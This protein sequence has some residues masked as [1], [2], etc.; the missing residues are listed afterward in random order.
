MIGLLGSMVFAGWMM[1][2]LVIPRLADIHGRRWP[3]RLSIVSASIL[4]F[5][6]LLSKDIRLTIVLQ[7]FIGVC[8]AGRYSTAYVYLSELMPVTCRTFACSMILLLDS[9]ILIVHSAYFRFISKDWL[10]F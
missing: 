8:C 7:F 1:A 4:Y 9:S 2:S 3:V 6:V 5:L 10:P